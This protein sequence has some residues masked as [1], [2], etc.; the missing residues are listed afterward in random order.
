MQLTVNTLNL[1]FFLFIVFYGLNLGAVAS[2]GDLL[3]KKKNCLAL[4]LLFVH[5]Q[6]NSFRK[7]EYLQGL[8]TG[9]LRMPILAL[10]ERVV[11]RGGGY[12]AVKG[13]MAWH[14]LS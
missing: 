13:E 12:C 5:I 9:C 11:P 8:G 4:W 2:P 3:E 14:M 1:S 6:L 7:H 10:R